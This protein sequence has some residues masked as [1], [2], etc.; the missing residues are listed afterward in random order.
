M[1]TKAIQPVSIPIRLTVT[2]S[3]RR[4]F[5]REATNLTAALESINAYAQQLVQD[6]SIPGQ[7]DVQ[8][9]ISRVASGLPFSL[10]IGGQNGRI[11]RVS[12]RGSMTQRVQAEIYHNRELLITKEVA[13]TF[14]NVIRPGQV[15]QQWLARLQ[16]LMQRL[17]LRNLKLARLQATERDWSKLGS[18]DCSRILFET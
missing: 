1:A 11:R 4:R 17:A 6:L 3:Q 10:S 12:L 16:A 8:V 15:S 18:Q 7:V 14:A 5:F 9:T 13:A 2:E